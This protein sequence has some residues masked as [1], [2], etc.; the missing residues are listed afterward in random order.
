MPNLT[1]AE[2]RS[3]LES[4]CIDI[5]DSGIDINSGHG[6]LL[7][8]LALLHVLTPEETWRH[9]N[10]T[11]YLPVGDAAPHSD[12]DHDGLQNYFEYATGGDPRMFTAGPSRTEGASGAS[13]FA[14]DYRRNTAATDTAISFE[15]TSQLPANPWLPVEPSTD[16]LIS[17]EANIEQRRAVFEIGTD[18]MR[19]FFRL[20]VEP[21]P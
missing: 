13:T 12:P 19:E 18:V 10:F 6:V 8:D 7:A 9:A 1:N 5:E 4:S 20:K 3:I 2:V 11:T 21:Q 15:K 16:A 17:T 14:I